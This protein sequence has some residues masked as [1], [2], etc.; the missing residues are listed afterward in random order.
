MQMN[1][2]PEN[3]AVKS[4]IHNFHIFHIMNSTALIWL[5]NENAT[6]ELFNNWPA[7]H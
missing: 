3:S 5:D 2:F 6:S 4:F 7:P 1:E